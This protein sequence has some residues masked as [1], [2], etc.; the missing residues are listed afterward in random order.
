M[1][2]T[3]PQGLN[4]GLGAGIG[5]L[6]LCARYPSLCVAGGVAVCRL[7]GGCK[8]PDNVHANDGNGK[9]CP[10]L[11]EDLVGGQ[12]DPR[13]GPSYGGG[14]HNSGPLS[15]EHGGTG[16]AG[17]DFDK[18][19]GGTGVDAPGRESGIQTGENGI[20]IRPGKSGQ[21]PRIDIPGNGSKPPETLHY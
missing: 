13:A 11:P 4:A 8:I 12:D 9:S 6:A 21:G 10:D 17:R 5:V 18:L 16:D 7:M 19:T 20:T 2:Y 14:R 3:D 1:R 15:P